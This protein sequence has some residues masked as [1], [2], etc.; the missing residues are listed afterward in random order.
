MELLGHFTLTYDHQTCMEGIMV[1]TLVY[2]VDQNGSKKSS[3]IHR[4]N[5]LWWTAD[6]CCPQVQSTVR[7]HFLKL[8]A[9]DGYKQ[10]QLI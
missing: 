10:K 2:M 9:V 4:V 5:C 7:T 6:G 1:A 8:R 3:P